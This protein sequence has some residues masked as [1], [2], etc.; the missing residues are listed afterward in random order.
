VKL[1]II[2]RVSLFSLVLVLMS[3][4]LLLAQAK[5]TLLIGEVKGTVSDTA[6][7]I[8][9]QSATVAIYLEKDSSLVDY[10]LS[11][12]IGAFHFLKLPLNVPIYLV[13]SYV[14]YEK[15]IV[16]FTIP[17]SKPQLDL[18]TIGLTRGKGQELQEVIVNYIPPVRM[19]GD[20]LEFN[21]DA[22]KLDKSAVVEDLLR[23]LPGVTVWGDGAITVNGKEVSN[24][25]VDGKPFL[26]GDPKVATQNL[27]KDAVEKIQVYQKHQNA[28]SRTDSISEI[29]I[30][31]KTGKNFGGFGKVGMGTD[32]S[33]RNDAEI[34]FSLFNPRSQAALVWTKNNVNKIPKDVNTILRNAT[35]KGISNSLE[36]SP[37][38]ELAGINRS[39]A[40][41]V[42]FQHDFISDPGLN[43]NNRINGGY[44][45]RDLRS[46]LK[47]YSRTLLG[48]DN[49]NSLEQLDTTMENIR[50]T[51]HSFHTHYN[52]KKKGKMLDVDASLKRSVNDR[53]VVQTGKAYDQEGNLLNENLIAN[54]SL[55][56]LNHAA[57]DIR[58]EQDIWTHK[59]NKFPKRFTYSYSMAYGD[60]TYEGTRNSALTAPSN[61]EDN[62][63][64]DRSYNN[65]S[66][67]IDQT[68]GFTIGS[69][70]PL[71]FGNG[72]L[73]RIKTTVINNLKIFDSDE[74]NNVADRDST[75]ALYK[76]NTYLSNKSSYLAITEM[77]AMR[78]SRAFSMSLANRYYKTLNVFLFLRGSLFW[79]RNRSNHA[80]QVFQKSYSDFI[81]SATLSFDNYQLGRHHDVYTVSYARTVGYPEPSQLVPLVDSSNTNFIISGNP[82]LKPYTKNEIS[83][84][85]SH[86]TFATNVFNYSVNAS[87][88]KIAEALGDHVTIDDAGRREQHLVNLNGY[89]YFL[90]GGDLKK[91]IRYKNTQWQFS[92]NGQFNLRNSPNIINGVEHIAT[93]TTSDAGLGVYYS[94]KELLGFELKQSYFSYVSKQRDVLVAAFRSRFWT[95]SFAGT[96][97]FTKKIRLCSDIQ[98]KRNATSFSDPIHYAIWNAHII[99]RVLK[100]NN[101]ECKFSAM[102]ML[103][104]NNVLNNFGDNNL[105]TQ[106]ISN[107]LQQY[108]MLTLAFYPRKFG[109]ADKGSE[110]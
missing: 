50:S 95:T 106:G 78:F 36:Y 101:L 52:L 24:V 82:D 63:F 30:R 51:G 67:S 45:L 17:R 28:L 41:G 55:E 34:S 38:F 81:P 21:A 98:Y 13:A 33:N 97:Q 62:R 25:K 102:D 72:K 10:Q 4:S 6:Y 94:F 53:D 9:L 14:G 65:Q 68:L 35:Y 26:T 15:R 20:T 69:L 110:K 44:F 86:E 70:T 16:G 83:F 76:Q 80:F 7:R 91:S 40:G 89:R 23:Q 8:K 29:N 87:V 77:P 99:L 104:Q 11:N 100:S 2:I 108:Y 5:D 43:K 103:G 18:K 75:L 48:I 71:L 74:E 19:N 93:I 3:N 32:F 92:L 90:A 66:N 105:I 60:R 73:S 88:G 96:V 31:L 46:G 54:K 79:Q 27:P 47:E 1:D 85:I 58:G 49:A 61:D 84:H 64:Y 42:V 109:K 56:R 12:G 22:F 57:F 37:D 39:H 59:S 107:S